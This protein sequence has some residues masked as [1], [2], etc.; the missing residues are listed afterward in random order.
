MY[1]LVTAVV[2]IA[3][4]LVFSTRRQRWSYAGM[5]VACVYLAFGLV[6]HQ[7]ALSVAEQLAAQRGQSPERLMV[8]PTLGNL[9]LWRVLTVEDG[10]AQVDAV[11]VG[12]TTRVYP[13]ERAELLHPTD[14]QH[15]PENSRLRRDLERMYRSSVRILTMHP[16]GTTGEDAQIIIGY[17]SFDIHV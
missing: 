12:R 1:P 6:Q 8:K 13:G 14:W 3:L 16:D 10:V 11:R 17:V 7:R 15:L 5:G 4:V 2:L 9:V